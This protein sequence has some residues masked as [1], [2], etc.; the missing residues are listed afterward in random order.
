[1]DV[2]TLCYPIAPLVPMPLAHERDWGGGGGGV[3]LGVS[4][5]VRYRLVVPGLLKLIYVAVDLGGH[6]YF[7]PLSP[8]FCCAETQCWRRR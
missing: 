6:F 5:C 3:R 2:S 8:F 1:M 4:G 7:N